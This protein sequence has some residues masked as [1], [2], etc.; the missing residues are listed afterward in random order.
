MV[1]N[2]FLVPWIRTVQSLAEEV[3]DP[4]PVIRCRRKHRTTGDLVGET[5]L[6]LQ[7][8]DLVSV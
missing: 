7:D 2:T 1:R 4:Q 8:C 5:R 6:E 3:D